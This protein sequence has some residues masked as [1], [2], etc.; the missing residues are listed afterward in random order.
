VL[1]DE[2]GHL[3]GQNQGFA[4]AAG[5]ERRD[6]AVWDDADVGPGAATAA[7]RY[8]E[9]VEL[10]TAAFAAPAPERGLRPPEIAEDGFFPAEPAVA[11]HFADYL[12]HGRDVA[13]SVGAPFAPADELCDAALEVARL[14]P[15]TDDFRGPGK[16][17]GPPVD[18]TDDAPAIDRVPALLGR[19]PRWAAAETRPEPAPR[20]PGP[21]APLV[22]GT[23]SGNSDTIRARPGPAGPGRTARRVPCRAIDPRGR[24]GSRHE[25]RGRRAQRHVVR[26]TGA[27]GSGC[28]PALPRAPRPWPAAAR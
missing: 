19:S 2:L 4:A 28:P 7:R 18:I 3:V 15:D 20:P 26:V 11:F 21:P 23:T 13:R 27:R 5:G 12:V 10:V 1:A 24:V 14:V 6:R 25:N 17:F 22:R 16:A 8:A 9:S